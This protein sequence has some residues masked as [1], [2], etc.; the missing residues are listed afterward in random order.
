MNAVAARTWLANFGGALAALVLL[1]LGLVFNHIWGTEGVEP[2]LRTLAKSLMFFGADVLGAAIVATVITGVWWPLRGRWGA[3]FWVS[4]PL[5]AGHGL[6]AAFSTFCIV[7]LGGP[8]NKQ[9]IGISLLMLENW[10]PQMAASSADYADSTAT[11]ILVI[12]TLAGGLATTVLLRM[13]PAAR[14]REM[15]FGRLRRWIPRLLVAE[16]VLT[17]VL[18]PFM[19]AGR[20]GPRV[21]SHGLE[22]SP[23]VELAWSYARPP[24]R[25]LFAG[26]A[27][28]GN[29]GF[30]YDLRSELA[31]PT[32][33]VRT[34]LVGVEPR[35][36]NVLVVLMESIG[37]AYIDDEAD[38]MPYYRS[39]R[40]R[41]D[42]VV[43]GD[44]YAT[45]SLTT[46]VLFSL[47][48]SELPYTSYES[49]SFVNPAIP[50]V[51][52]TETLRDSG[53]FTAL[54]TAG[55]LE[56]DR[57]M[58]FLRHRGIELVWDAKTLPGSEGAWRGP[59][60]LEDR[61]AMEGVLKAAARAGDKPFFIIFNQL[62]G[63]HPFIATE[64]QANN[65][66]PTRIENYMRSLR[67]A[68]DVT[69]GAIEGLA[70]LGLLEDTLVVVVSDHGEGHGRLAGRNAYQPVVK[71]PGLMFGPQTRGR[72]GR[73]EATT[74]QLDMAP[75]LLGLLGLPVP[76]TMKGRDL[77]RVS[78]PRI[79]IFGGRPPKFQIGLADG[80]WNYILEDGSLD[81]LFDVRQDP[82]EK[83]NLA[84]EH[85]ALTR[86][87]RGRV[88]AW[89][90]QSAEL[91]ENYA[92]K[93]VEA[94]CRP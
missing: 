48:C 14:L 49:I 74:S 39:L 59:W 58:R 43:F 53:Y 13:D 80:R 78:E 16:A 75:T 27:A 4:L 25:R 23:L 54:V 38:P 76:C 36:T 94:G 66:S 57:K 2:P 56:F 45:W 42:S 21:N 50:C 19:T 6:L 77:T 9:F 68:D 91:I 30:R 20:L 47:L 67:V 86:A 81:M 79:A 73:I 11:G 10:T 60:G 26:E 88:E 35:K 12:G 41:P 44:H 70:K 83:E 46:K 92:T 64:A 37:D 61:I 29:E 71:V 84:D 90:H 55:D 7:S 87:F 89:R 1:K 93:M 72:G 63:H 5:Q 51:S 82:T 8:L 34:P 69:R 22:K 24:I 40:E 31:A 28:A 65:P 33:V 62:A 18:L 17:V 32:D 3:R 52:L 85:P 15:A